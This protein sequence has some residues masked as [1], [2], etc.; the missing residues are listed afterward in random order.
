MVPNHA[1]YRY[2]TPRINKSTLPRKPRFSKGHT[3]SVMMSDTDMAEVKPPSAVCSCRS[4]LHQILGDVFGES[5]TTNLA[6]YVYEN[7]DNVNLVVQRLW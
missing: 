3:V 4:D 5:A 1:Y 6:L 2:T 7:R